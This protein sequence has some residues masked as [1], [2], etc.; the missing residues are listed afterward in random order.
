MYVARYP[1]PTFSVGDRVRQKGSGR[2]GRMVAQVRYAGIVTVRW[3]DGT[4]SPCLASDLVPNGRLASRP[5]C[6]AKQPA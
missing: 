4:E 6:I 1:T 3:S 2:L 5:L